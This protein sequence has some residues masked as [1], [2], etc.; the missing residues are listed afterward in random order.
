MSVARVAAAFQWLLLLRE[1]PARVE[2]DA[3]AGIPVAGERSC[4]VNRNGDREGARV[5]GHRRASA[6]GSGMGVAVAVGRIKIRTSKSSRAPDSAFLRAGPL[7][8]AQ[9]RERRPGFVEAMPARFFS[10]SAPMLATVG[11][12]PRANVPFRASWAARF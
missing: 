8:L 9:W 1:V 3:H 4:R 7:C 6:V 10:D 2:F 5:S 12:S 11:T